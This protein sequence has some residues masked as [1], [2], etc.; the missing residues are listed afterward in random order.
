MVTIENKSHAYKLH[1]HPHVTA[2]SNLRDETSPQKK[3][4]R[5]CS[6]E[7]YTSVFSCFSLFDVKQNPTTA[8]SGVHTT[9]RISSTSKGLHT[10]ASLPKRP[11][12]D[13]CK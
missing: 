7:Q 3:K 11:L 4:T 5:H 13:I 12:S 2:L 10:G 8:G 9:G 6:A 1:L